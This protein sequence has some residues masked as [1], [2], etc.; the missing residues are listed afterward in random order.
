[1][2]II[3][4]SREFEARE[5]YNMTLGH[6]R[7]ALKDI[8][9]GSALSVKDYI[10]Y[11]DTD[12]DDNQHE[13]MAIKAVIGEGEDVIVVCQ[14]PSAIRTIKDMLEF[15]PLSELTVIKKTGESKNNRDYFYFVLA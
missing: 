8:E 13:Y 11:K 12:R 6:G 4:K 15:I 14:S 2:E 5:I 7:I 3:E 10:I 9:D 1:M